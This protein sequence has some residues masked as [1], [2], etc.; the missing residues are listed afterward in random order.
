[1]QHWQKSILGPSGTVADAIRIIEE[2]GIQFCMVVDGQ[3][4]LLG[5]VTDGDVRRG[6][7]RAVP[8]DGPVARLM[9]D[10]PRSGHPDDSPERLLTIMTQ[11]VIRQLPLC[12]G[13]GHVVGLVT[14]DELTTQPQGRDN[15]VLLMAGGLGKRLRPLT[16][17]IPKPLL[18]VGH[19][20][21]LETIL[22]TFMAHGFSKFYLS[23]NYKAEMVKQHFGDG[24]E[25]NCTV[26]YIEERE[27]L[28]TAGA[29]SLLPE[30]PTAPIIV[31]NGDVLT[32]VNFSSLLDFHAEQNSVATMC[33]REYDFQVPYGVVNI[34]HGRIVSLE[35]KPVHNFFVNAGIYVLDPAV[36][37]L[38]PK[39][40]PLDMP[41]LFTRVIAS[42]RATAVFPVREYW[43][44][45]GQPDD[46]T[47]A[48]G[49]FAANFD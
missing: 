4:R 2:S 21:L 36:V 41:E 32:K 8:L 44:D 18:K 42:D 12:D 27:R 19:K 13:G 49:D 11:A 5:T 22:E 39:E 35:E 34:A 29:L 25:W 9:K 17:D 1:M 30:P 48:N 6:I 24:R 46:F 31:M 10:H 15:W 37:A 40:Q 23:V 28:G 14:I 7:L 38:V 3:Y 16:D 26:R 45:I 33:V 47:H 20:P 43:L